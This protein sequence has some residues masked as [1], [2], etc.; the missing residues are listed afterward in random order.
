MSS[1][2]KLSED[3]HLSGPSETKILPYR[4][5]PTLAPTDTDDR[6]HTATFPTETEALPVD[7]VGNDW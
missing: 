4:F 7:R 3:I 6:V 5:E 2:S 1:S